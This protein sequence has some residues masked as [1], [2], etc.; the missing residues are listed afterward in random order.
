MDKKNVVQELKRRGYTVT[1][2]VDDGLLVEKGTF[3]GLFAYD[4]GIG[5]DNSRL[6][7]PRTIILAIIYGIGLVGGLY[8]A[9]YKKGQMRQEVLSITKGA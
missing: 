7:W 6:F 2:T 4:T 9:L 5:Q 1:G 8:W 3:W